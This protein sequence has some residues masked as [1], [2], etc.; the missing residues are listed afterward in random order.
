LDRRRPRTQTSLAPIRRLA[1]NVSGLLVEIICCKC[2]CRRWHDLV[3]RNKLPR[4]PLAGFFY[5]NENHSMD[6]S[7]S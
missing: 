1:G 7:P 2:V 6:E 5:R 4:S 3:S